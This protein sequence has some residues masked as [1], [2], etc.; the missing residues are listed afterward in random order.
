MASDRFRVAS[1]TLE[2]HNR[3]GG[4]Q[5][6]FEDAIVL[7]DDRKLLTLHEAA[8]FI[9]HLRKREHDAP[10]WQAAIEALILVA[11][12]GVDDAR[13]YWCVKGAES[14]HEVGSTKEAAMT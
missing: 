1:M 3:Q 6:E 14:R 2:S 5:R 8:I 7:S 10:E 4:W 9:T 11:E 12:R 13:A